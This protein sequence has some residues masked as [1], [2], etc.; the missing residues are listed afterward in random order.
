[1]SARVSALRSARV[2]GLPPAALA[3]GLACAAVAVAPAAAQSS[4]PDFT[5]VWTSY[6]SDAPSGGIP[7]FRPDPTDIP[8]TAEGRA[9]HDAYV[10]ATRG[11]DESPG[12]YCVGYGMPEAM[13]RS[14]PY[15][16]EIIQR[17]EQITVIYE[18]HGETRRIYLDER[19]Q[20]PENVFPERDGFSVGHWEGDT[21]IVDTSLLKDQVDS[22]YPHS[23][24]AQIHEEYTLEVEP[25]GKR[26]LTA[27]M[28][29]TDPVYLTEPYHQEK[30]WQAVP[31]GRLMT[32]ECTE[33]TWLDKL[34]GLLAGSGVTEE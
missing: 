1:M 18:L 4:R 25:S 33:P 14:G 24:Q 17:P 10:A 5:G 23:E 13:L 29:M 2:R 19:G 9:R 16:M 22:R 32:Y 15:P 8:Y 12:A 31:G 30:K 6:R 20:H 3:L 11:T 27:E 26:V 34:N 28:T 21:L 7:G